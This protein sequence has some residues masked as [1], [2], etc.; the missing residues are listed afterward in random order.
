MLSLTKNPLAEIHH[1][2]CQPTESKMPKR[3]A[4]SDDEE[5]ENEET[6]QAEIAS[7]EEKIDVE[8]DDAVDDEAVDQGQE[9]AAA[10]QEHDAAMKQ[11]E[12]EGSD[13]EEASDNDDEEDEDNPPTPKRA[14][15]NDTPRS[16]PHARNPQGQSASVGILQQVKVE[17]FMCHRKLRVDLN[18]NINFV[19]GQNGSGKSAILAALQICLGAG[20]RRTHRARNL[21]ALVRVDANRQPTH[22]KVSVTVRNEGPDAFQ[23]DTYGDKIT[24]ERIIPRTGTGGGYKLY[25]ADGVEISKSRRDLDD[26][27]DHMNIQVENP[28]AILDQEEAKKFL[29]GAAADKYQ[30]F[31]KACELERLDRAY[32]AVSDKLQDMAAAKDQLQETVVRQRHSVLELKRQYEQHRELD[33]L[34]TKLLE[35][36]DKMAWAMYGG[37]AQEL[38]DAQQKLDDFER[39]AALKRQE[40]SQVE[41]QLSQESA[42]ED[43]ET[44]I[45]QLLEKVAKVGQEKKEFEK[46][47]QEAK[48]PYRASQAR[49]KAAE[50][51]ENQARK[52]CQ[53]A[54]KRLQDAIRQLEEQDTASMQGKMAADLAK[55]EHELASLRQAEPAIKDAIKSAYLQYEQVEVQVLQARQVYENNQRQYQAAK[56]KYNDMQNET[57]GAGKYA[58][59]GR[60][61]PKV[62]AAIAK[63]RD[64]FKG[65]VLGP[66]GAHLK[67]IPGKEAYAALAEFAIGPSMLDR[68]IVTNPH[69]RNLVQKIRQ[70]V[71]CKNDCGII[72]M[73]NDAR[74]FNVPPPPVAGVETVASV[75]Q[76]DEPLVRERSF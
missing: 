21:A 65:P 41:E 44:R 17:N 39:K 27:L 66:I 13:E 69:D 4:R 16:A 3:S 72:L 5:E 7:P 19:H 57:S 67:I 52:E 49:V 23:H 1:H 36:Q 55:M 31:M 40:L 74:R 18:R 58:M 11:E 71:G 75:L 70:R 34:Q 2:R 46:A 68:F 24:V 63:K 10:S 59:W 50:R 20:A 6:P 14:R 54:E 43:H 60:N 35:Q 73:S 29:T 53:A 76:I 12:E 38:Q 33:K 9:I 62:A 48:G 26:M 42:A 64:E 45:N 30:F 8:E 32:S 56:A 61:A 15:G 37:H 25:N 22:A 51:K 28:V 47:Y